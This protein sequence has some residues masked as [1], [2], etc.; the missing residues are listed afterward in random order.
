M[1]KTQS[2][3][4]LWDHCD[5]LEDRIRSC[6]A[7]DH[8]LLGFE[9]P[10]TVMKG[11]TADISTICEYEWYEWVIYNDTTWQ[12]PQPKFVLIQFLIPAIDVG[13][14]MTSK[15]LNN[16][17]EIFPRSTLR[18]LTMQEMDNPDLKEQRRKFD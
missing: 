2:P 9:V 3:K 15:I 4:R 17:G 7:H 6:T 18:P 13:S 5:E 10:E 12:F 14:A 16:T 11:H 8:Y 1:I